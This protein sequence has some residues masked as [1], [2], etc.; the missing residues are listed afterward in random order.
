MS[1]WFSNLLP[2]IENAAKNVGQTAYN[3]GQA[4]ENPI[5]TLGHAALPKIIPQTTPLQNQQAQAGA[6]FGMA[7]YSLADPANGVVGS[8]IDTGVTAAKPV[9]KA[10]AQETKANVAA[11]GGAQRGFIGMGKKAATPELPPIV[12]QVKAPDAAKSV[13]GSEHTANIQDALKRNGVQDYNGIA[14]AA[15]HLYDNIIKPELFNTPKPIKIDNVTNSI[16]NEMRKAKP[17]IDATEATRAAKSVIN[18]MYSRARAATGNTEPVPTHI[19]TPSLFGIKQDLNSTDAVKNYY[20]GNPPQD[21]VDSATVAARNALGKIIQSA[22][23]NV[24][25]A[26]KDYGLLQ[27]AVPSIYRATTQAEK[28]AANMPK[29]NVVQKVIGGIKSNP[30]GYGVLALGGSSVLPG[31]TKGAIAAGTLASQELPKIGNTIANSLGYEPK[32]VA[33]YDK[34]DK[35]ISH[36]SGI[37]APK[38]PE[39]NNIPQTASDVKPAPDGSLN[40]T[41]PYTSGLAIDK[42]T[43]L[44]QKSDLNN[45]ISG[46]E[47]SL[48]DPANQIFP[49]AGQIQG[50]IQSAQSQLSALEAKNTTSREI[51]TPYQNGTVIVSATKQAIGDLGKSGSNLLESNGTI[52]DTLWKTNGPYSGLV[53]A[54]DNLQKLSGVSIYQ[55]GITSDVLKSNILQAEA[56]AVYNAY[57][58]QL[59]GGYA[60]GSQTTSA[61]TAAPVPTNTLP[62]IT[63]G[64]GGTVQGTPHPFVY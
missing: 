20:A 6:E 58:S 29:Q 44:K 54:V 55:P 7:P 3:V 26:T 35:L 63:G 62:P 50:Q 36:N 22:H 51:D 64:D 56:I 52:N 43:Y 19:D 23:P 60:G 18:D 11:N 31:I 9:V 37:V 27:D 41:N 33:N 48:K 17:G 45:Q 42:N 24:A 12:S 32:T 10:V 25:Q 14:A 40:L 57:Y 53:G 21:L 59:G 5:Q 61:P 16:V 47:Q 15:H 30:V 34:G 28:D 38:A 8:A 2:A 46:L 13:F 4:F 49:K 1:Q 39:V